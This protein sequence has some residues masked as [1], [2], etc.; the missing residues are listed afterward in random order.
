[1]FLTVIRSAIK[2]GRTLL[3]KE[4]IKLMFT[5]KFCGTS[6]SDNPY[7]R[8]ISRKRSKT[9]TRL[10]GSDHQLTKRTFFFPA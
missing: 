6:Q 2:E 9:R 5:I 10:N 4:S 8:K 1:M 3:A 7:K